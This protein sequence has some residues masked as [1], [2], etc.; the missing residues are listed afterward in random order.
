MKSM[1]LLTLLL[2]ATFAHAGEKRAPSSKAK[3]GI[4]SCMKLGDTSEIF[5]CLDATYNAED[6]RLNDVYTSLTSLLKSKEPKRYDV[7][8]TAELAWIK[9]CE[10]DCKYDASADEA[11][12]ASGAAEKICMIRET[13]SRR[14]NLQF[15]TE[16]LQRHVRD[17]AE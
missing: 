4:A 9:L 5:S 1:L 11:G 17:S 6:Q 10:A 12:D 8:R 15:K 3:F 2:P 16:E 7:V 13:I 14:A